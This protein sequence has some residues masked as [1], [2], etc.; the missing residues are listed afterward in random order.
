MDSLNVF[1]VYSHLSADERADPVIALA[2]VSLDGL[3]LLYT[4]LRART[5]TV[6]GRAVRNCAQAEGYFHYSTVRDFPPRQ[7]R[8]ATRTAKVA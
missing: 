7:F 2:A 3:V 4:P 5:G 1:S 8:I 6:V